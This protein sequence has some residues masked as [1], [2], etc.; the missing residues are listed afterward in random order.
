MFLQGILVNLATGQQSTIGVIS[1]EPEYQNPQQFP[2]F[3]YL[4]S[5]VSHLAQSTLQQQITPGIDQPSNKISIYVFLIVLFHPRHKGVE[6]VDP[7]FLTNEESPDL[8]LGLLCA[9]IGEDLIHDIGFRV[10]FL[11]D[12]VARCRRAKLVFIV[13]LFS[14]G[15]FS[16]F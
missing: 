14:I 9:D 2:H 13:L 11:V 5:T 16:N 10:L 1:Q 3:V 15:I 4:D 12:D 7:L 8:A 6:A